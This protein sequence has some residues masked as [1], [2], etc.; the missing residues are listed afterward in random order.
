MLKLYSLPGRILAELWFLWPKKGQ[1]RASGRRRD[2]PFVHFFYSTAF[3]LV[4]AWIWLVPHTGD[5]R[6]HRSMAGEAIDSVPAEEGDAEAENEQTDTFVEK[7]SR[8]ERQGR[9]TGTGDLDEGLPVSLVI[10][11]D[12]R[13]M[14]APRPDLQLPQIVAVPMVQAHDEAPLIYPKCSATVVDQCEQ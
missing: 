3:Y 11:A 4:A 5:Q 14:E 10:Q 6:T 7:A 1:I 13:V 2:H 9:R 8:P 12:T